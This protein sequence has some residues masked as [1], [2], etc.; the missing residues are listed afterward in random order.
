M[1]T[2]SSVARIKDTAQKGQKQ[3]SDDAAAL[4]AQKQLK[5]KQLK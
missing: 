2:L 5:Q 3:A 4:A 1:T